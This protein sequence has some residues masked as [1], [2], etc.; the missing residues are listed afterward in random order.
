MQIRCA[1]MTAFVATITNRVK[2]LMLG[3]P[4]P[5]YD[6]PVQIA[7]ELAMIDMVS[8]GRLVAGIVR[9]GGPEQILNDTNPAFNRERFVEAHDLMVDAWTRPGPWRWEG[10]HYHVRLVNPWVLPL[11]RPHPPIFVPGIASLESI[12]F[13]A[14]HG[15][16]YVALNT[17]VAATTVVGFPSAPISWSPTATSPIVVQP[18]GVASGVSSANAFPRP[19][20]P[21]TT[22]SWPACRPLVSS[23]RSRKPV[24]TPNSS[25]PRLPIASISLRWTTLRRVPRQS[26]H[27][28]NQVPPL[29]VVDNSVPRA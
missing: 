25:P 24:G 2:L 26:G 1:T 7:E 9:G 28:D 14:A 18:V 21:A 6:N 20:R 16:P 15:Y 8:K 27:M 13:A 17:S 11:Q 3:T 4:L 19:G 23:S 5:A 10:N 29:F 22:M 12:D